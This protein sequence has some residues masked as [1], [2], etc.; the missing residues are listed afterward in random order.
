MLLISIMASLSH[1]HGVAQ[2]LS[3]CCSAVVM[4]PL[5]HRHGV[6]SGIDHVTTH[7]VTS[8]LKLCRLGINSTEELIITINN[9]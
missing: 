3:W 8:Q 1:C 9:E 7:P 4:A 2:S 5:R 6:C